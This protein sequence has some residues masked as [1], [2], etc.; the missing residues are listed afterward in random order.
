MVVP[1]RGFGADL[2]GHV[3]L[4]D[5]GPARV[6]FGASV[7]LVR[8]SVTAPSTTDPG[9]AAGQELTLT[10][11]VVA[12][13]I[14]FNFGS[15]DGWSYLSAGLGAGVVNTE[16]ALEAPGQH[17]GRTQAV[18]FGGGARWFV[19]PR[20]AFG[21]DVRAHQLAAGAGTPRV[22]VVAAGAGLSIR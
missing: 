21:V 6:G 8:A 19:T 12:P 2:G 17:S 16:A 22:N 10:M 18:N 15:R 9:A 4:F 7:M 20:L 3:Y 11:R 14:S 1:S 5:L 13:Q